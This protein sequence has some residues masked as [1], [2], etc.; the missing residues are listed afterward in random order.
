[1]TIKMAAAAAIIAAPLAAQAVPTVYF[2][3][4]LGLGEGTKLASWANATNA[5]ASFLAGLINPGV[6]TF[7][8]YANGT[9]GPLAINFAGAGVTATLGAGGSIVSLADG[10][11]NGVGRY[12]VTGDPDA[13][14]NFWE[15]SSS[16]TITFSAP[17][18]A[19]GFFGIDIG[20][21][22]GQVTV[23]TSGGLNQVFNVGNTLNGNGGSV[24]FWG[25]IDTAATFTSITFGNT[26]PGSDFFAFDNFTVGSLAQVK[27]PTRVPE[28]G[29]LLLLS[30]GLLGVAASRKRKLR[31]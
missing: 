10:A 18:A 28:P 30:M 19:F 13:T 15:T 9:G 4:T 20:D 11:T 27:D 14:E 22:N 8:S 29:T 17:V 2:G 6:E 26:A 3:E 24:L 25:V 5:Q 1:M 7:E 16:Q 23:T 31:A 21:F 12:G